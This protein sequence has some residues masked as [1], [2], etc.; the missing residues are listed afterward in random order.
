MDKLNFVK[1]SACILAAMMIIPAGLFFT[2]ANDQITV[3]PAAVVVG[4]SVDTI[5]I[6]P[7]ATVGKDTWIW[8][9]TATNYTNYGT[10]QGMPIG[11]WTGTDLLRGLYYIDLPNNPMNFNKVTLN[12]YSYALLNV[13]FGV[14]VSA[15]PL[16]QSW[17]EDEVNWIERSSG[18][19]WTTFGGTYDNSY[20]AYQN[21]SQT[22]AW[23]ELDITDIAN[24]WQSGTI[25]NHGLL[26]IGSDW[27]PDTN[28]VR[29]YSSDHTVDP[30][31]R[32]KLVI[33]A[34]AEIDPP[35]PS[36]TF[37]EDDPARSI[38]LVGRDNGSMVHQ[39]ST[40]NDTNLYPFAGSSGDIFHYQALYTPEMVGAEGV[41]R[42]I[43]FNRTS[44]PIAT[45]NFSNFQISMAHT[46]TD[47]LTTT[48]ANNYQGSLIEVF[49]EANMIMNSSNDDTWVDFLLND[50]FTYDSQYNL[51]IDIKWSGDSGDNVL[52]GTTD[53]IFLGNNVRLWNWG[54][55][56][57]LTGSVGTGDLPV[58]RFTTDVRNNGIADDGTSLHGWPFD[59]WPGGGSRSQWLYNY[60]MINESG[61]INKLAFQSRE[62]APFWARMEN[63]SIRLAH[64]TNDT[65][66]TVFDAHPNGPW[67]TV[68]SEPIYYLNTSGNL[69]WFEIDVANTFNYNGVDN[70]LVDIRWHGGDTTDTTALGINCN[71][72][73]DY[74]GFLRATS[75]TATTGV[76][77]DR[78]NNIQVLFTESDNLSWSASSLN[79]DL[80]TATISGGRNLVITPLADAF[81]TGT[82][83]LTLTNNGGGAVTQNIPVTINAVN[84]APILSGPDSINCTEDIETRVNMTAYVA[85]IDNLPEDMTYS[86]SSAFASV[87]GSVITFLYPE[88]NG[89]FEENVTITVNDGAGGSDTW[90]IT[91]NIT[92][93]N[94]RPEFTNYVSTLICDAG[95]N[96]VYTLHPEDEETKTDDNL[97]VTANSAYATVN[98][99]AI[100]FNYPK[101]IGS[102]SVTISLT[103]GHI[104]GVQNTRTY[105]LAVTINDHPDIIAH[106]PNGTAVAVTSAIQVTF[107]MPM[108]TTTTENAFNFSKDS[109]G[110]NGT[111]SWSLNNTVMTFSPTEVLGNGLYWVTVKN[112]AAS[113]DGVSMFNSYSWNFTAAL[114]SYDGDGDG[115]PDQ[116]ELDNGLD[117]AVNDAASDLDGDGM[118]NLYEY[119]NDL[120]P[121]VNDADVDTDG[122]G[123]TNLEEYEAGTNPQDVSD[124]PSE[125]MNILPIILLL[126]VIIGVVVVLLLLK[127]KKDKPEE[128]PAREWQGD[129]EPENLNY[130]EGQ[131]NGNP[132]PPPPPPNEPMEPAPPQ[133]A[134]MEPQFTEPEA[135]Q[136]VEPQSPEAGA[137]QPPKKEMDPADFLTEE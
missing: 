106:S 114:G 14:N 43:A 42:D 23:F 13:P 102:E 125:P 4:D 110:I 26:L 52:I 108:N 112:T 115:M 103:D 31:L 21:F 55:N 118:P 19:N 75:D 105:T 9:D 100:T 65:L 44:A 16:T 50:N 109:I 130:V 7:N 74:N 41:I 36:Q 72:S 10:D 128:E 3:E 98:G 92:P 45:G 68:L 120:N 5:V 80:F 107:D 71:S 132:P 136:E 73:A 60:S 33:S 17:V 137:E 63:F 119:Q 97:T 96:K 94:D 70:L 135:P 46:T 56:S 64:S 1:I 58:L 77:W 62:T 89:I 83:R 95:I 93:V 76:S 20:V 104:Y 54:D 79:P 101:G 37:Q 81:G 122:D 113:A 67:T 87:N 134:P 38:S 53:T 59:P 121:A 78:Y 6:Q 12:L 51:L 126:A 85:D 69:E 123:A 116:Y 124:T 66:G 32:P 91:V 8:M 24:A 35:V 2:T 34:A 111:F 48:Y 27:G 18:T 47:S 30:S 29:V 86:V 99:H 88:L 127:G 90:D 133:D 22:N 28:R 40:Q 39:S 117:P 61:Y 131:T 129:G 57:A 11:N 15:Y 25:P 84:D 82:A 49:N